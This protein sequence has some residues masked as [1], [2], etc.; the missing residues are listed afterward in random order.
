MAKQMIKAE[1]QKALEEAN[2]KVETG[3]NAAQ[4][5]AELSKRVEELEGGMADASRK[6]R[7]L[8]GENKTLKAQNEAFEHVLQG[9]EGQIRDLEEENRILMSRN[10]GLADEVS[11]LTSE[12]REQRQNVQELLIVIGKVLGH[13]E[14]AL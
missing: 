2:R 6:I 12:I 9:R 10:N 7:N 11:N 3:E 13:K 4:R 5:A 8:E 14:D 1:L